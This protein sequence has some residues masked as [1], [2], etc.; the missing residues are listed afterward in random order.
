MK[1][2]RARKRTER[3]DFPAGTAGRG[4]AD[5]TDPQGSYTGHPVDPNEE[6]VQDADDL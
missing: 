4:P 1:Q 5:R 3:P 2:R 6:P